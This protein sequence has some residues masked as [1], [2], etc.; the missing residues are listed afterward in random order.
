MKF[1]ILFK[2]FGSVVQLKS[3]P[4]FKGGSLFFD[5]FHIKVVSLR[6]RLRIRK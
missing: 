4:I 3:I 5:R 6:N 1:F 2:Y